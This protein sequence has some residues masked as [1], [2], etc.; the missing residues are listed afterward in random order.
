VQ[1]C[2]SKKHKLLLRKDIPNLVKIF[3]E[4]TSGSKFVL[5]TV[6]LSH[7]LVIKPEELTC[8]YDLLQLVLIRPTGTVNIA[9]SLTG[10]QCF[11][12]CFLSRFDLP[13][14]SG[15]AVSP[16]PP[17]CGSESS[18]LERD[19]SMRFPSLSHKI[20]CRCPL[21]W[22]QRASIASIDQAKKNL[23]HNHEKV[24]NFGNVF[25]RKKIELLLSSTAAYR[26]ILSKRDF[27]PLLFLLSQFI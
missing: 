21:N 9:G 20:S 19:S 17:Q 24:M 22:C 6:H 26:Y 18:M 5:G 3:E 8:R 7:R 14:G 13:L 1:T 4:F 2:D 11:R 27:D 15:S 23:H 25:V 16:P 10:N 12:R